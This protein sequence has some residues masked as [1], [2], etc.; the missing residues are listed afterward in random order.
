MSSGANQE[1]SLGKIH[2]PPDGQ[3]GGTDFGSRLN[4]WCGGFIS[5]LFF[6]P[7]VGCWRT[8]DVV[9]QKNIRAA[10]HVGAAGGAD[11]GVAALAAFCAGR[12]FHRAGA[13]RICAEVSG[14]VPAKLLGS[15]EPFRRWT[16]RVAGIVMLLI[17]AYHL[18]YLLT[19]RDGRKLVADLF[20]S[21]KR[22]GGCPPGRAL[23]HRVVPGQAKIGRFGYAE[24]M[25]ILGGCLGHDHHGRNRVWPSGSKLT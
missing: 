16:H 8:R 17:G 5:H 6:S 20:P 7:S 21:E 9:P 2:V 13:D 24:K 1:F 14:F 19:T 10:A 15:S 25:E 12:Q 23:S 4:H 3:A 18:V 11:D 22:S